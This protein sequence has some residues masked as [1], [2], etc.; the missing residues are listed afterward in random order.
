MFGPESTLRPRSRSATWGG[1]PTAF[2]EDRIIV[3]LHEAELEREVPRLWRAGEDRSPAPGSRRAWCRQA[4]HHDSIKRSRATRA[5]AQPVLHGM[6]RVRISP[7]VVDLGTIR[8]GSSAEASVQLSS[9]DGKPFRLLGIS[10]DSGGIHAAATAPSADLAVHRIEV[11]LEA[12]KQVG[13]FR[14]FVHVGTNRGDARTLVIPVVA[15]IDAPVA[16]FPSS[17]RIDRAEIGQVVTR[18]LL[19]RSDSSPDGP[20]LSNIEV[21]VPWEL[22]H[23]SAQRLKGNRLSLEIAIL[24]PDGGGA[25]SGELLLSFSK[26]Q[27]K[28]Y[29][30]PLTI[31]GW[32]PPPPADPRQAAALRH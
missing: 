26:P 29:R 24:F 27:I 19:I 23:F 7:Q 18:T 6:A 15:R 2:R 16:V 10:P 14:S 17:L 32:T 8:Q 30:I 1:A 22:R 25:E 5:Q 28:S 3:R 11:K 13:A 21:A 31:R 4:L 9:P 20:V 12:G